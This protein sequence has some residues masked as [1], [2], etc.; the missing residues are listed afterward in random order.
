M[1]RTGYG[2]RQSRQYAG[3]ADGLD[4]KHDRLV[5]IEADVEQPVTRLGV[6]IDLNACDNHSTRPVVPQARR[7]GSAR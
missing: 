2:F 3:E 6:N 1:Q 7:L 5:V 4:A